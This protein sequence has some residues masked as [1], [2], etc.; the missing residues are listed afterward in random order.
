MIKWHLDVL[1][2]VHNMRSHTG[3]VMSIGKEAIRSV[4][5]KQKI[6]TP[7]SAEAELVSFDDI[8]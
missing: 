5:C 1:F 8:F 2:A 4:S 6:N 7:S 3:A